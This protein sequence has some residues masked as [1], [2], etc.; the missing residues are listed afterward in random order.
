MIEP[1]VI[2][3]LKPPGM[4]SHDVVDLIRNIYKTKKVGH[5]GTLDPAATGVL[6]LCL[7]RATKLAQY[8]TGS[9]KTYRA[10][11]TLGI[12]TDT[13]D[14]A[15]EI[16]STKDASNI[17]KEQFEKIMTSFRG[18][19]DQ[20]PPMASA[21]KIGGKKLYELQRQGKEI[22]RSLR[23]VYIYETKMVWSTG[24][25]TRHPRALFDV[26]CSKGTYI[27]TICHDIGRKIG[28]GAHMSFLL[29]T[30]VGRFKIN[31]SRTLEELQQSENP[32]ELIESMDYA[33]EEYPE[34]QVKSQAVKSIT[35]GA[36]LYPPGVLQQPDEIKPGQL[37]RL[38]AK[39]TLLALA[40]TIHE[41]LPQP[42]LV[43]KPVCILKIN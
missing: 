21:I 1:G 22:D 14:A 20:L 4:T 13:Q 10:E 40:V 27:R 6:P 43:Y 42:R 9:D 37:V 3:V 16:T 35:S 34:I 2:N 26:T 36:K 39:S 12:A 41:Q 23:K 28:T 32:A 19:I 17:T 18:E 7:G 31:E 38:K 11:I 24:W 25:G 30:S 5:T 29:R 33:L 15:G 8:I